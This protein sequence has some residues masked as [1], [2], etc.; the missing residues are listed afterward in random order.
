MFT[1]VTFRNVR[2]SPV[3]IPLRTWH[4][5][6]I[7]LSMA[8]Q[9]SVVSWPLLQFHSRFYTDGW[10]PWTSAW[11]IKNYTMKAY[12][13][14]GVKIH[15]FLTSALAGDEW[16]ASRPADLEPGNKPQSRCGRHEEVKILAPAGTRTPTP[17]S[18]SP[19]PAPIPTALS[20]FIQDMYYILIQLQIEDRIYTLGEYNSILP[21]I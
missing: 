17:W 3:N 6:F 16:S 20:L 12:E 5:S 7:H 1:A 21:W 2:K 9:P 10:T 4:N 19:E 11:L 13:G 18:S 8:V 14:V 15:I